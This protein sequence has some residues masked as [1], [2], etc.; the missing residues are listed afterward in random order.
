[1]SI[2]VTAYLNE[3]GVQRSKILQELIHLDLEFRLKLRQSVRV[4]NYLDQFPG[5]DWEI[6]EVRYAL[7]DQ[8]SIAYQVV[9]QGDIDLGFLMGWVSH[10]DWFWKE[11]GFVQFL[12]KLSSFSRLILFD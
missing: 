6:P 1:M 5:G 9:G 7:N 10:L 8:V 3:A 2:L 4:E 11:P 12:Q